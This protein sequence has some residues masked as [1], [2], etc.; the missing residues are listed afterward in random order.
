[1][2]RPLLVLALV[3][4]VST[5]PGRAQSTPEQAAQAF[6]QALRDTN[7][8]GAARLMHPNA[9]R[10]W[11]ALFGPLVAIPEMEELSTT[12]FGVSPQDF[13]TTPDTLLFAAFLK[14]ALAQQEGMTEA[15]GMSQTSPLGHVALGDTMLVVTRTAVTVEG[16][17]ITE[18]DV[19]PF[20][21][22]QG[23]WWGLLKSDVT[24]MAALMQRAIEEREQ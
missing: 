2:L 16:I 10:Q 3:L 7:W 13:E 14:N 12:L 9:L 20:I 19:M 1:M 6:G 24:N 8:A 5:Q 4:G 11:R 15:L 21:F 23:R 18:F 22:D 17:P